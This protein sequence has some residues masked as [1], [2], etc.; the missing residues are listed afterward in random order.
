[1][2]RVRDWNYDAVV[3]IGGIG[4][5]A[6]AHKIDRKLNW[7]GVGPHKTKVAGKPGVQVTF[8]HFLYYG[9][10][11]PAFEDVAPKLAQRIY[12]NNVRVLLT[13]Y[14]SAETA[15]IRRLLRR[16]ATAPPSRR[17]IAGWTHQRKGC[18]KRHKREDCA[19]TRR[20]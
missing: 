15:E 3:G 9:A 16:A 13:A 14:N 4:A 20:D 1:M 12:N 10:A 5:E 7:I 8:D 6:I 11:G 18:N 19:S 2:G 17:A